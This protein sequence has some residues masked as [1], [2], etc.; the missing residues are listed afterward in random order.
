MKSISPSRKPKHE[1][2]NHEIV[3]LAAYLVGAQK[4][5]ADT[6]DVAIKANEIAPGRFSWRKYREQVNI[7]SVRK[8]LWDATRQDR[9]AY[10][11]RSEKTGWRLSGAY[12]VLQRA[13][14]VETC[15]VYRS[16]GTEANLVVPENRYRDL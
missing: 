10:L 4:M 7:E 6:E 2:A 12:S 9:G 8:R 5:S 15:S 13:T 14:N 16:S 3:V 1:L 11:I